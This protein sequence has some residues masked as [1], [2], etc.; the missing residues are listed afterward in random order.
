VLALGLR[1]RWVNSA[2]S[3]DSLICDVM[4]QE[5][6]CLLEQRTREIQREKVE[7][8]IEIKKRQRADT[9]NDGTYCI[10]P[11]LTMIVFT[12]V[13][14]RP[15]VGNQPC[16]D[17]VCVVTLVTYKEYTNLLPATLP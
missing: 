3:L 13:R 7:K 12:A 11:I 8:C 17:L 9:T 16:P 2:V 4:S 5:E 10:A 14:T 15:A 6:Q 1:Q